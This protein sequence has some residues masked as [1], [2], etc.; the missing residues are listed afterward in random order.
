MGHFIVKTKINLEDVELN[1][2]IEESDFSTLTPSGQF[3]QMQYIDDSKVRDHKIKPGI[4]SIK[5][6]NGDLDLV[7]T[8]FTNDE[9]LETYVSTKGVTDKINHFFNKLDIY[10]ELGIEVPRRGVLLFGPQGTGKTCI[11]NKIIKERST[12]KETSIVYWNTAQFDASDIKTFLK[13]IDYSNIKKF[14]LIVEDIGG[15]EIDE[16]RIP[17]DSSLL[18]ILDN[19]EKIF[20]A[21]TMIIAT[22]N[23][24]EAFLGNITNRPQRFDDKIEVGYP[25]AEARSELFKFVGKQ[26]V[27]SE[28]LELIKQNKYS[29]FSPAHLR[30][31]VIRSRLYDKTIKE[32]MEEIHFEIESFSK[33]FSKRTSVGIGV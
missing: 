33:S 21:P 11:I 2:R 14:I 28:D 13:S 9:I 25:T 30:E 19:Q 10:K 32:S 18:S 6:V 3:V 12:D 20:T 23:F 27:S 31:I 17:S 1:Q 24:P 22:T 7:E 5:Y 8:S 16:T 29:K 26:Y 15:I 4:W